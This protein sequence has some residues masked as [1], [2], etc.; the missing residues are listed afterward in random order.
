MQLTND[1]LIDRFNDLLYFHD[2][3]LLHFHADKKSGYLSLSSQLMVADLKKNIK[4]HQY[5]L[6][7]TGYDQLINYVREKC[8]PEEMLFAPG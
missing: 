7:W 5:S 3:W 8:S 6:A 2:E 1:Q 4:A